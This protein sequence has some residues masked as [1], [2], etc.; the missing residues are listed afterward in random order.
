MSAARTRALS[1]RMRRARRPRTRPAVVPHATR[2]RPRA[3][4]HVARHQPPQPRVRPSRRARRVLRQPPPRRRRSPPEGASAARPR[5]SARHAARHVRCPSHAHAGRPLQPPRRAPQCAP[6]RARCAA[7]LRCAA[8]RRA[9]RAAALPHV[10]LP[11]AGVALRRVPRR[12][13][14]LPL[15]PRRV[16]TSP[17]QRGPSRPPQPSRVLHCCRHPPRL[18]ASSRARAPPSGAMA[19]S[20]AL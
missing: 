2:P 1:W 17:S 9:P 15:R 8:P 13:P 19:A 6:P 10:A 20:E 18:P 12:L 7:W 3:P 4:R 5:A 14:R 16:G 11:P